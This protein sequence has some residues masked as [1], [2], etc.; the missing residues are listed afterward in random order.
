MKIDTLRTQVPDN[1]SIIGTFVA[2]R[3]FFMF[4]KWGSWILSIA[5]IASISGSA[6]LAGSDTSDNVTFIESE[7][8]ILT[9][10]ADELDNEALFEAYAE[11]AFEEGKLPSSIEIDD[12]SRS[13]ANRS[14]SALKGIDANIYN[15]LAGKIV[16]VANGDITNTEFNMRLSD[17]GHKL[18]YTATELGFAGEFPVDGSQTLPQ[19]DLFRVQE[20]LTGN[21]P[22]VLNALMADY[23]YEMYWYDITAGL[24]YSTLGFSYRYD[25]DLGDYI[26]FLTD[27]DY[28]FSF[29]VAGDFSASGEERT[30]QMGAIS[31]KLKNSISNANAI[32]SKYKSASDYDKLKGYKNEVG[33]LNVYNKPASQG[34]YSYKYGNP[35]QLIWVF[36][37]DTSTN[38]VCEGYAKAYQYLCDRTTFSDSRIYCSSVSGLVASAGSGGGHMWNIVH[39]GDGKNYLVD[40]TWCD[41]E[42]ASGPTNDY[43]MRGYAKSENITTTDEYGVD[44]TTIRYSIKVGNSYTYYEFDSRSVYTYTLNG[45]LKLANA[46]FDPSSTV[47]PPEDLVISGLSAAS[48]GKNKVK[49]TWTAVSGADGYLVYGQKNKK[50]GYVGMTTKGTSFTDTKALSDDYNYYW[51]FPYY[52]DANSNMH[53]GKCTKYVYAK[54]ICAPVASLKAT[55]VKGGVKLTWNAST[56]AEGYLIYGIVDG[57]PYGYVGMTTKG[58]TFT[59][60]TASATQYNYYWV[61]PYFKDGSGNMITGLPGKYIYGRAL[62]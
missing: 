35:W 61:Y 4:K 32:V 62:A 42:Y 15:F 21:I 19:K 22:L 58:T 44:F 23:P 11:S 41:T 18:K 45:I 51:V 5:L 25:N 10:Q 9:P 8:K 33:N 38:V 29:P 55:S 43:F 20:K 31:T 56:D 34:Q 37:G 3:R 46:D 1:I 57:K 26:F 50:Y 53:A 13:G 16:S 48:A 60:K 54:G 39:M 14:G 6:V 47:T 12:T 7:E 24:M 59:D 2:R 40:A 28:T 27:K 49:L 36:D 30:F 52:L 17:M